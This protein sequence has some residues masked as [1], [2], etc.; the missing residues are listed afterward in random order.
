MS[1]FGN[2]FGAGDAQEDPLFAPIG[3]VADGLIDGARTRTIQE[4]PGHGRFWFYEPAIQ[5]PD[6]MESD[7]PALIAYQ[8]SYGLTP[9]G[10]QTA[11]IGAGALLGAY[12]LLRR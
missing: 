11:L 6:D 4:L 9:L 5:P 12:F 2:L 8:A 7:D 1:V 3:S 10:K